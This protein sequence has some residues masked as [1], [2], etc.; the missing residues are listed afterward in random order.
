M[1]QLTYSELLTILTAIPLCLALASWFLMRRKEVKRYLPVPKGKA[2]QVHCRICGYR[3][4]NE[5]AMIS[6]CTQCGAL[7]ENGGTP[8]I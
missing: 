3:Y 6:S 8:L 1:I 7:N 5:G 2:H 4:S